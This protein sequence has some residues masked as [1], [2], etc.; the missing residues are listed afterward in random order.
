MS[1][2]ESVYH[3]EGE[4]ITAAMMNDALRTHVIAMTSV[5]DGFTA[6]IAAASASVAEFSVAMAGERGPELMCI[7]V[8]PVRAIRLRE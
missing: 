4:L 5:A 2:T 8:A 6:G 1:W 3:H 7:E